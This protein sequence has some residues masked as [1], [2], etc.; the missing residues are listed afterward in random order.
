MF[1]IDFE[2][3]PV[4]GG[5]VKVVASIKDPVVIREIP[6]RRGGERSL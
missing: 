4:C 3:C 2:T 5:T 1:R 6:V